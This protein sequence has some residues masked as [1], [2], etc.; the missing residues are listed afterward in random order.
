MR[1]RI[2]SVAA[3]ATVLWPPPVTTLLRESDRYTRV[4]LASRIDYQRRAQAEH[5]K[6]LRL[7]RKGAID[8]AASLMR[9]HILH[10][11]GTLA[12]ILSSGQ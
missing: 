10:V 11:S 6:L 12:A 8:Q 7:C 2:A 9:A 3:A 4:Q 1:A 5:A